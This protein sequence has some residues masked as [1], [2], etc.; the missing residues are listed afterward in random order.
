MSI[1]EVL[2][3]LLKFASLSAEL[4]LLSEEQGLLIWFKIG[5]KDLFRSIE[6]GSLS[7]ELVDKHYSLF[8]RDEMAELSAGKPSSREAINNAIRRTP[9]SVL[10]AFYKSLCDT[11]TCGGAAQHA[12]I[13]EEI[14][15]ESECAC[16]C[17][18]AMCL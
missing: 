4:L 12:S 2:L 16:S 13:A 6:W 3:K 8:T 18:Q 15:K 17:N 9:R 14:R 5:V 1:R 7:A 11:Q 10:H